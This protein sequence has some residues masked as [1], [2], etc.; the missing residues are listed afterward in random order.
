[1][2][3]TPR[4][5]SGNTQYAPRYAGI[6]GFRFLHAFDA[7]KRCPYVE[8]LVRDHGLTW[9]R[10]SCGHACGHHGSCARCFLVGKHWQRL[11]RY[12]ERARSAEKAGLEF[13]TAHNYG[14]VARSFQS[15]RRRSLLTFSHH[16][17]VAAL[18]AAEA[19]ALL[20]WC[21]ETGEHGTETESLSGCPASGCG[22]H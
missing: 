5:K 7:G 9:P 17:E 18:P 19:D 3:G 15:D 11:K 6:L 4:R 2:E 1:M 10:L 20:D 13:R 12:G 22:V 21:E 8:P 16:A 14:M